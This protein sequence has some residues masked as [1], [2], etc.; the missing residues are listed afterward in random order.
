MYILAASTVGQLESA[1]LL[2]ENLMVLPVPLEVSKNFGSDGDNN[3]YDL[4]DTAYSEV[5]FPI[6]LRS[7]EM[8]ELSVLHLYQNWGNYPL[9]QASSIEFFSPYYHFSTGVTE[10]N[11]INFE[12][13][14]SILPDHRAM[15][16]PLWMDQ[17]QH[18]AGGAH[19]FL[20]Y[21]DNDGNN[22]G[23]YSTGK[24]VDS[25]GPTYANTITNYLSTD[26][27][28]AVTLEHTEMPQTD[29]NRA[30]Y[31]IKYEIL[32]RKSVV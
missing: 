4:L 26:N 23:T 9:K 6:A 24:I 8:I 7:E 25:Y 28:I 13:P 14:Q 22:Q 30:Y 16:A 17:P 27:K 5:I 11:C 1:V 18:T 21:T 19:S 15:S 32:D 29:E 31:T 12:N 3:I 2:D 10:T 20:T